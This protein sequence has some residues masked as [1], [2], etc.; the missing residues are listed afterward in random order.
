MSRIE[1]TYIYA[2]LVVKAYDSTMEVVDRESKA[3]CGQVKSIV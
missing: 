1:T 3:G 2:E